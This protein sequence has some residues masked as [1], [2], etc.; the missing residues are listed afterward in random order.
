MLSEKMEKALND[1]INAETYSS[2]IYLAM[3]AYFED[4]NM[5]GM[6]Q[7]MRL[8]SGEEQMHAQKFYDYIVERRGRVRLAAIEAP[9][10]EWDSP[11]AAFENA[12]EHEQ[13]ITGRINK[14]MTLAI[15][16]HDHATASFLKWFVDEQ[17]EEEANVDSVVQDLKRV[18]G[19]PAGLF[20]LDRELGQR[21]PAAEAEA[22][23]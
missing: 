6:A 5:P 3:V 18:E 8:Q 16:E 21:A 23:A 19:V 2:Y 15:E 17:V 1:Q 12:F 7:W 4:L 11:L 22:G 9:P 10:V 13:Y 20:M 14:L